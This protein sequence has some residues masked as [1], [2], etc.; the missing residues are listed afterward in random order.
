MKHFKTSLD[1]LCLP[2]FSVLISPNWSVA[3]FWWPNLR[4]Q[5]AYFHN[6]STSTKDHRNQTT[7][8]QGMME[9]GQNSKYFK[10]TFWTPFLSNAVQLNHVNQKLQI[11]A[12]LSIQKP[13]RHAPV[14]PSTQNKNSFLNALVKTL[15]W[16][17]RFWMPSFKTSY[18]CHNSLKSYSHFESTAFASSCSNCIT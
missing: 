11:S 7:K 17:T 18:S 1:P 9:A 13:G 5:G 8:D 15:L 2:N 4:V 6:I 12:F 16:K 14:W 3:P 10:G